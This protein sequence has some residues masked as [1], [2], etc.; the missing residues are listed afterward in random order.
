MTRVAAE[1]LVETEREGLRF[2]D[3]IGCHYRWLEPGKVDAYGDSVRRLA[4]KVELAV[5]A[6]ERTSTLSEDVFAGEA[7]D[8]LRERAARR[9][10]ESASVRDDLRGLGRAINAYSDVLRRHR[11]GLEQLRAFAAGKGLEV[12]DHR[13][14]PPVETL[15]GD[16]TRQQAD[17]WEADWKAYQACFEAKIE[18]RDARRAGTR[19]LVKAL[20]DHAGVHPDEDGQKLVAAT[21]NQVRFGE[22]RREAAEEAM[23][24]VEAADVADAARGT[25]E[26]LK[27]R[28]QAALDSLEEL[29]LA[30][31]PHEEISAQAAKVQALHR[32]LVDARVEA[33]DAATVAEREQAQADR[34]A[35]NLEAADIRTRLG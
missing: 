12:R 6:F 18:L 27:R 22:L 13:I 5:D 35:R 30:E 7:A 34:A 11:D 14:W 32:E 2:G 17:A 8:K 16:A 23:E 4:A 9:H 20:A 33:R 10:E 1:A 24:A 15:P 3:P 28:E 25:V 26:A 31:A 19:E 21:T 29:V